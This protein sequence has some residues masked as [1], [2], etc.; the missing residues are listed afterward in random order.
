MTPLLITTF[1]RVRHEYG[2]WLKQLAAATSAKEKQRGWQPMRNRVTKM[3]HGDQLVSGGLC[4]NDERQ[5]Q[6]QQQ[7]QQQ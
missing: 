5:Q 1:R 6:Q 7:Q 4:R 2:A 3:A